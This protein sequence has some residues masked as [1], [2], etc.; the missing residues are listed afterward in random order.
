MA[1][2]ASA[3]RVESCG[4]FP[5]FNLPSLPMSWSMPQSREFPRFP[6]KAS[7][8]R[9][10]MNW[11][12]EFRGSELVD[13]TAGWISGKR[14]RES[15]TLGCHHCEAHKCDC[16]RACEGRAELFSSRSETPTVT[17]CSSVEEG[18]SDS[19]PTRRMLM[20]VQ[21]MLPRASMMSLQRRLSGG[22]IS[23]PAR[24]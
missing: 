22:F 10:L 12:P 23:E 24:L 18:S 11:A 20:V 17:G 15:D 9:L 2:L 5:S 19:W 3:H 8:V 13:T 21:D 14:G 4:N 7:I 16:R 1:R 6:T